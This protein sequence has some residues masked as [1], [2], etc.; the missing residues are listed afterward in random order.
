MADLPLEL[1]LDILNRRARLVVLVLLV[2]IITSFLTVLAALA[3]ASGMIDLER[4]EL[5]FA[6]ILAVLSYIFYLVAFITSVVL[7]SM[8]IYRAHANLRAAGI[9][10]LEYSP[11]W[12][13]GW[14]FV[15]I[16]HLFKPLHAMRELWN[17]SH[18]AADQFGDRP[19][20]NLNLWWGTW[21]IGNILSNASS[22]FEISNSQELVQAGA[23]T[24]ILASLLLIGAA[25]CLIRIVKE[26]TAAQ[27]SIV[28]VQAAFA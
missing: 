21:I 25:W 27:Q 6:A 4:D 18:G 28:G 7:V 5:D 22:R 9:E 2:F 3:E 13:I 11:A 14:Y 23:V 24:D 15:P 19:P 12:A 1:G 10:G 17:S 16:A 8:W 20:D 26:V